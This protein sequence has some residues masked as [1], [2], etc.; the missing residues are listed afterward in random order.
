[1]S[2]SAV[3]DVVHLQRKPKPGWFS[4]ERLFEDVRSE[5]PEDVR[6]RVRINRNMS[7]GVLGRLHDA[8]AGWWSRGQVNHVLG[9]VHYMSWFL[10]RR[11]TVLTVLDCVT[12]ERLTGLRRRIFWLLWYWWPLRRS[13][14]VTV[15]SE[16]SAASLIRWTGIDR[17][18]VFV[19]P[20][21]LSPEFEPKPRVEGRNKPRLLHIGTTPNK[22]LPRVIE[23]IEGLEVT[24]AIVGEPDE[25]IHGLLRERGIEH[26]IRSNLSR[27]DLVDEYRLA[28][29]IVFAS[30][31]EGFGLPIIEGQA[32]GRP[33][34]AGDAGAMPEA[35]GGA[36]CMV[37][38]FSVEDI[39]RGILELIEDEDYAS[40]LVE[41]GFE[42]A[43]R[44]SPAK[45][46][47]DY[48][49][50]YRLAAGGAAGTEPVDA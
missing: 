13:E 50:V 34:V 11:R 35:A 44:F 48:A 42:N 17:D 19:I 37:D 26:E 40:S 1:M 8:V 39:R 10:P 24:L 33:V 21:P 43:R 29:V 25:A 27:E 41:R 47:R 45:L 5:M 22:N 20:P 4:V 12:L 15:I 28:D 49:S 3:I 32:V 38:P 30:T 9:D 31:Y 14:Y 2:E 16:Y 7:Q 46:A 18:R 6:V 23:A 36:A